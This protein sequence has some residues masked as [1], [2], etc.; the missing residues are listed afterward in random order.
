MTASTG[1]RRI[2]R[3]AEVA[4]AFGAGAASFGLVAVS[5]AVAEAD[6]LVAAV[7]VICLAAVVAIAHAWGVA[8]AAWFQ[9]PPTHARE[10]PGLADMANLLAYIAV[11]VLIGELAA[12][13]GR[14]ADVTEV[15]RNELADEQAAMRRVAATVVSRL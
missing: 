4:L 11:A 13:A 9:F 14:R 6:V 1:A 5:V 7:G 12:Y 2:A 15:A 8:Y 3:G 10:F